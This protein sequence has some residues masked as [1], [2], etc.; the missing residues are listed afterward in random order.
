MAVMD[1]KESLDK[2]ADGLR[3][4]FQELLKEF[5]KTKAD[6]EALAKVLNRSPGHIKQMV[7]KG[8]GGLDAWTKAFAYFYQLD[9]ATLKNLKQEL[10]KRSPVEDSDRIWFS[11]RE[12]LGAAEEDLVYLARCA[13]EACRIK[14]EI[15]KHKKA[16]PKRRGPKPR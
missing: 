1:E 9:L 12:D 5:V 11:I 7:Y 4:V 13:Y 3:G 8:E 10:R 2:I 16:Q 15:E 6:R 14:Q